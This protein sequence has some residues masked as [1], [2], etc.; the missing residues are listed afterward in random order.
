[1]G[2]WL[3]W[4]REEG[5]S[6]NDGSSGYMRNKGSKGSMIA[7]LNNGS[8]GHMRNKGSKGSM[9]AVLNDGSSGY[10]RNK[11]SKVSVTAAL[12]NDSSG[13]MRN[14]GSKNYWPFSGIEMRIEM[15]GARVVGL[16]VASKTGDRP[17]GL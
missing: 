16:Q 3:G 17:M 2:L 15:R 13:H 10:M 11:G 14:K 6:W 9:T 8:S 4:L 1:M 7:A 5:G 12:N